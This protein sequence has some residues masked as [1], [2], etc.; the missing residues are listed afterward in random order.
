[1]SFHIINID[2][3]NE[4]AVRQ[5]PEAAAR[6]ADE[7]HAAVEA[8]A[9]LPADATAA[10]VVAAYAQWRRGQI[11]VLESELL[12]L[13]SECGVTNRALGEVSGLGPSTV[14][15]RIGWAR[16]SRGTADDEFEYDWSKAPMHPWGNPS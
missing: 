7:V 11:E 6:I 1:M 10:Q 5:L 4:D 16:A 8:L 14:G 9:D 2:N 12:L 3:E 13:L 15:T